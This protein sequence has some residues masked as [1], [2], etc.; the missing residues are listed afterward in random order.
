MAKAL[1]DGLGPIGSSKLEVE[2]WT[3]KGITKKDAGKQGSGSSPLRRNGIAAIRKISATL[4]I[5]DPENSLNSGLSGR[6]F[7]RHTEDEFYLVVV[8][9][10]VQMCSFHAQT[11]SPWQCLQ[12]D[13]FLFHEFGWPCHIRGSERRPPGLALHSTFWPSFN[14]MLILNSLSVSVLTTFCW[15]SSVAPHYPA[16]P[17]ARACARDYCDLQTEQHS[18][19]LAQG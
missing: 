2:R 9:L 10:S 16:R 3:L 5:K 1:T 14:S 7:H 11:L 15:D 4:V 19:A 18:F 13:A 12:E 17:H 8:A 6:S